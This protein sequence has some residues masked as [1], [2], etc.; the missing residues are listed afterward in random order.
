MISGLVLIP[1]SHL[2]HQYNREKSTFH[3]VIMR[4]NIDKKMYV[5]ALDS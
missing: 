1:R 5:K 2:S 4:I 3:F